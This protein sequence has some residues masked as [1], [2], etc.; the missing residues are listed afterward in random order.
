[1][2]GES[3][4]PDPATA[5]GGRGLEKGAVLGRYLILELLGR[6]GMGEV[7]A[8]YDPELD[9]KVAI[10]LLRTRDRP[11]LDATQGRT[12]LLREAQAIAKLSHPNVIVVH[13]VGTVGESVFVA[14]ELIDGHTLGYWRH[15]AP[16]SWREV[17]GVF[18][19]AGQGL[20]AAHVAGIVHRD[21]KPENVMITVDGQVRVMDFGLARRVGDDAA[22]ASPAAA[23]EIQRALAQAAVAEPDA[24]E[25]ATMNLG[26]GGSARRSP[27]F[28]GSKSGGY[29]GAK[30]T[31]T[32]AILGTPAYMAPEQFG[33]AGGDA[34][35]D[36]FSFCVALYEALYEQ[37][38]FAGDTPITL[39][40]SVTSGTVQDA[41][42]DTRVPWWL[43]RVLLRGLQK[44][45]DDR[46]P[47][48]QALLEALAHDPAVRTRRWLSAAALVAALAGA[49]LGA[50][51]LGG[52]RNAIC[53][54]GAEEAALV[55]GPARARNIARAFA[56]TGSAQATTAFG[57]VA[58]AL[59]RY[60]ANWNTMYTQSCEA[61]HVRGEQSAE[62][63]D[64][65]TECLRQR[66]GSVSALAD[67]LSHADAKV[68]DNAVTAAGALPSLDRC[69]DVPML[70]A[71]IK[72]P[73]DAGTR[74]RV[75]RARQDVARVLALGSSGQ[76]DTAAAEGERLLKEATAIGYPPLEAE[77]FHAMGGLGNSCMEPSKA[78]A[79]LEDAAY[80]AE[81]ARHDEIAIQ[82]ATMAGHLYCDRLNDVAL[83]RHWLRYGQSILSRVP[84][85]PLLEAYMA[86]ARVGLFEVE[87]RDQD[88]IP[89]A[90]RALDLKRSVFTE[91]NAEVAIAE[92]DLGLALHGVGRDE[93]AESLLAHGVATVTKVAGERSGLLALLL[94]DYG[95]VLTSLQRFAAARTALE[96]ALSIWQGTSA[97]DFYIG[98]A[99]YD[100]GRLELAE[101]DPRRAR[102]TLEHALALLGDNSGEQRA[103]V[104]FALAQALWPAR[105][106]RP[107]AL[108][109]ARTAR[110]GFGA[111]V[112]AKRETA[113]IDEW[114]RAHA[115]T[116]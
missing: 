77:A 75:A 21:F 40:T 5:R 51:H 38:P 23:A 37:R 47:S 30:L 108:Q 83:A 86:Q 36:Q 74:A 28:P 70:R 103:S 24:D 72:P 26:P 88:A 57:A 13:D 14:M 54:G 100:L 113:K 78:M 98:Y 15:A 10:K 8:A 106:E 39:M 89:E 81:A 18:R 61:T 42:S 68:V 95:E 41:P 99:V 52:N 22:A 115:D 63:L 111:S 71:V 35:A 97:S 46:Y 16:R 32:G 92:L 17:L 80:A 85:H 104:Q 96:R 53:A 48:M 2:S 65:R 25:D 56:A 4:R 105:A 58:S 87:G 43:R 27:S 76:C 64:L 6:G 55:W 101:N 110:G 79:Y 3:E 93:E 45:P 34:R 102:T 69:A 91:D 116:I 9:R 7:Y 73:D 59:D 84:G 33:G 49:A 66:L 29:L 62:V 107:K 44:S 12:R 60:V 114:L 20:S 31:E 11:D 50:R 109:M 19:A 1:M 82:A 67:V 94:L 90:K 112:S